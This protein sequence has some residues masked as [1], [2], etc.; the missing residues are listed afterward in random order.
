MKAN[1]P[2][3]LLT[4]AS[5]FVGRYFIEYFKDKYII[6]AFARKNQQQA[7][8]PI[9]QNVKW[10]LVDI[11]NEE[12]LSSEIQKINAIDFVVHLAGFYDFDNKP[13]PEYERTNVLGTE[14]MLKFARRL[15]PKRFLFSSSVAACDFPKDGQSI[16]ENTPV[17]ADFP[18]AATKKKAEALVQDYSKYYP[19]SIVRFAAVFSDWCEYG[20]LYMFLETWFSKSW[21]SIVLGGKGESAVPYIH[22]K[23]LNQLLEKIL[24]NTTVLPQFDTYIASPNG[25]TSHLDL[26]KIGTRLYFGKERFVVKMPIFISRIGVRVLY[27]LGKAI[28]RPTF[29]RPWMTDYIDLKLTTDASYT[30]SALGWEPSTRR[31]IERRLIY[32]IEHMRTLPI[33]WQTRN[34]VALK[35]SSQERPNLLISNAL[36]ENQ[37]NIVDEI[38]A[39]IFYNKDKETYI[40]YQYMN[41]DYLIWYLNVIYNLIIT[42]V[43]TGNRLSLVNYAHS[44]ALMRKKEGFLADEVC[45]ALLDAGEIMMNNL[46]AMPELKKHIGLIRDTIGLS[47]QMMVDEIQETFESD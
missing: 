24:I 18:Y 29:E 17:D 7:R 22:Q 21:N 40:H 16:D 44:L 12:F 32:L 36:M 47:T 9:H 19:C 2:K 41:A 11:A 35:I 30:M 14:L 1:L 6:Y 31:L 39:Q 8:V 3:I 10:V 34:Q 38:F 15:N 27:Y 26:Y 43:R 42:S 37:N 23:C 5:G 46:V 20:P 25:S 28:G 4:G 33:E 13:D 45:Q